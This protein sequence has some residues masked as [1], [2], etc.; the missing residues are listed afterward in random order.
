MFPLAPLVFIGGAL[1]AQTKGNCIEGRRRRGPEFHGAPANSVQDRVLR[2]I[3][4]E[5]TRTGTAG[6]GAA[7]T[8]RFL[9]SGDTQ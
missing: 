7:K 3:I 6:T 9:D 5:Y 4:L 1:N 8:S 2:E